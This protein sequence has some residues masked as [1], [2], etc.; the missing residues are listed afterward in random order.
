MRFEFSPS[1][2]CA[3]LGGYCTIKARGECH[4]GTNHFRT[5]YDL[6]AYGIKMDDTASCRKSIKS[7]IRVNEQYGGFIRCIISK[8]S[9]SSICCCSG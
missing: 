5:V 7:T 8:A 6:L 2:H 4:G 9:A 3:V 1:V